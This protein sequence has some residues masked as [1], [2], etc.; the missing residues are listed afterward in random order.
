MPD[1]P[2]SI[3]FYRT[4]LK[5]VITALIENAGTVRV[6]QPS[7][8]IV[9]LPGGEDARSIYAGVAR[10]IDSD[11]QPGYQILEAVFRYSPRQTT[12]AVEY[13]PMEPSHIGA[14]PAAR[15]KVTITNT[16]PGPLNVAGDPIL[17][18]IDAEDPDPNG[19]GNPSMNL[20]INLFA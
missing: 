13:E 2:V 14:G 17:Y 8:K 19:V 3:K 20:P 15:L 18:T 1:L 4:H 10:L 11:V 5:V 12:Q 16:P 7:N 9:I 6:H